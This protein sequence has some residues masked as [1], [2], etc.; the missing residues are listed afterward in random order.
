MDK[1]YSPW[2]DRQ[3]AW[4]RYEADPHF[5]QLVDQ[6]EGLFDYGHTTP[7][8]LR[9]ATMLAACRWDMRTVRKNILGPLNF[10]IEEAVVNSTLKALKDPNA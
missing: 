8:E 6:C 3:P 5:R 9:E 7:S 4:K 10:E 1:A 2:S